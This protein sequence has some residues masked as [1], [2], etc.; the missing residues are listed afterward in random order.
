MTSASPVLKQDIILTGSSFGT[1]VTAIK[2]FIYDNS[3]HSN[4]YELG[5]VSL[6]DTDITARLGGGRTGDYTIHAVNSLGSSAYINFSYEITVSSIAPNFG[7]KNGGTILTIDGDNFSE[8]R[9][10]S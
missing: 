4:L 1:D 9:V 8:N 2:V 5:I 7:S 10:D 6:T 3:T